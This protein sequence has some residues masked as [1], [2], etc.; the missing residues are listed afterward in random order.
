MTGW[1]KI[2]EVG[3]LICALASCGPEKTTVVTYNLKRDVLAGETFDLSIVYEVAFT[4]ENH[5]PRKELNAANGTRDYVLK[6]DVGTYIGR[7]FARDVSA[8]EELM[9]DMFSATPSSPA[10]LQGE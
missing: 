7:P 5:T 10:A 8:R 1:A 4:V 2:L 3:F 9:K 6:R